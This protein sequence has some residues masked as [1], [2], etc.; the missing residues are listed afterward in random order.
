MVKRFLRASFGDIVFSIVMLFLLVGSYILV[1]PL[2]TISASPVSQEIEVPTQ[3]PVG[4]Y[5]LAPTPTPLPTSTV[6]AV[7]NSYFLSEY[8]S[9]SSLAL[10]QNGIPIV[11]FY[12]EVPTDLMLARCNS[13]TACD[14]PT[15]ITV[16]TQDQSGWRNQLALDA[17]DIPVIAY[18]YFSGTGTNPYI[19]VARCNNNTTCDSPTIRNV[20]GPRFDKLSLALDTTGKP[21]IAYTISDVL[22]DQYALRI[23]FCGDIYCNT[24]Q[25]KEIVQFNQSINIYVRMILTDD[26]IPII[27]YSFKDTYNQVGLVLC[28][29]TACDSPTIRIIDS[30]TTDNSFGDLILDYE[31]NPLVLYSNF[32][33]I[34]FFRC[35]N[36]TTCDLPT[37]TTINASTNNVMSLDLNSQGVPIFSYT[38]YPEQDLMLAVCTNTQE[39]ESADHLILVSQGDIS[40]QMSLKMNGDSPIISYYDDAD[41]KLWLYMGSEVYAGGMTPT[42]SPASTLVTPT[43]PPNATPEREFYTTSTPTLTW[44]PVSWAIGYQI[45]VDDDPNFGSP[46]VREFDMNTLSYTTPTLE[47]GTYYWQVRAKRS[48]TTWG[49]W[50]KTDIFVVS[51]S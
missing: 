35:N 4:I 3:T 8:G 26:D 9:E 1:G 48:V 2:T 23:I 41:R 17:N 20:G 7:A 34:K 5:T 42:P 33:S 18:G 36:V 37:Y 10:Q 30:P 31:N 45:Q 15:F 49:N 47:N 43:S 51:V 32:A 14:S 50:S 11:S 46:I 39:C 19:R 38:H 27:A 22:D 6:P 29:T 12:S 16:A 25:E 24:Y 28:D 21:I 44:S 13:I 40:Y